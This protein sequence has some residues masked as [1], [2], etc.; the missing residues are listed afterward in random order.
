MVVSLEDLYRG[1]VGSHLT[2]MEERMIRALEGPHGGTT[3]SS[4][5]ESLMENLPQNGGRCH[6]CSQHL[7]WT[8]THFFQ[9]QVLASS[10][11]QVGR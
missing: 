7:V 11:V 3:G 5:E 2:S 10:I 4:V 6:P 9:C 1:V 8:K